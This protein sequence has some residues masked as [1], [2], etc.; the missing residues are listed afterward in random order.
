MKR[1]K[2][3]KVN[4]QHSRQEQRKHFNWFKKHI[5]YFLGLLDCSDVFDLFDET[6]LSALYQLRSNNMPRLEVAKGIIIDNKTKKN[7]SSDFDYMMS[8]K[9]IPISDQIKVSTKDILQYLSLIDVAIKSHIERGDAKNIMLL[10]KYRNAVP[11]FDTLLHTAHKDLESIMLILGVQMS[12]MNISLCWM[13]PIESTLVD[14]Y[15]RYTIEIREFIPK[16]QMMKIDGH[17]RPVYPLCYA[18]ANIGPQEISIPAKD[19]KLPVVFDK[20]EIPVFSQNHLLHRLSERLDCIPNHL[21][22]FWLFISLMEPKIKYFKGKILLEY[23]ISTNIKLGYII[24]EFHND[25]LL[26]KT[27]LLLSQIGTPE[28]EKLRELSG[29]EK[30]DLSYWAIDKLSTFQNSD[31]KDHPKTRAMIKNAGCANLFKEI[32]KTCEMNE[33]PNIC[34]AKQMLQYLQ[35]VNINEEQRAAV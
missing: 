20:P 8:E 10:K 31:L 7:I 19:I 22:Q 18:F 24:L 17:P 13:E 6:L 35:G 15:K 14:K 30:D 1:K 3:K 23:Y 27:F 25:R 2:K 34:Q 12:R 5:Q 9:K 28:G 26:A 4:S 11:D 21:C 32:P 33:V 29:M 16:K